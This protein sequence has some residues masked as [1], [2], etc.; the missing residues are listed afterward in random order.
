M[1]CLPRI[2][3]T[4]WS[5]QTTPSRVEKRLDIGLVADADLIFGSVEV[6]V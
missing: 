1:F 2:T 4:F 3:R 5:H 6:K